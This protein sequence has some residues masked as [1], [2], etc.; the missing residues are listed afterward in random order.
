MHLV[1]TY[2]DNEAILSLLIGFLL[3]AIADEPIWF[4]SNG[5]STSFKCCKSRISFENL[6]ALAAIPARTFNTLVS[7]FLEYVWPDTWITCFKSHFLSYHWL[8][9]LDSFHD[10]HQ[11][12]LRKL[13]CVPVVP[14]EPKSFML[15]NN[16]A[17]YLQ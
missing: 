6:C 15:A 11:K 12:V 1:I 2:L 16:I 8:N 17:Q 14:L 7:T 10:H 5:S 13:A 3:Y 9:V 4:F